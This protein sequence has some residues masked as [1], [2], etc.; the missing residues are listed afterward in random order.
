MAKQLMRTTDS[1]TCTTWRSRYTG[2]ERDSES[3]LD[4]FG[5]RYYGSSMGR[6]MSPD[7]GSDQHPSNPQSWNLYSYGRN[8]PLIGTDDDGHTYNV[9]SADGKSC[10]NI[11]DK[12][13]EANQKSDQANGV[14]YSNGTITDSSG[15]KQGSFSHDPDIAGDPSANIAA[16]GNIGNQGMGAIKY[17]VVGSVAGGALGAAGIAASGVMS[18]TIPSIIAPLLPVV[19]SAIDKLKKIGVSVQ[20]ANQI[21]NSPASQKLVDNLN[22]GNINFTQTVNGSLVRITTDPTG[23]RII[24]AGTMRANQITNGIA[25]GRFTP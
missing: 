22:G 24:S 8:N 2:K 20:Q 7:D 10:S 17:F 9:C 1:H 11:D 15:S 5:A 13:F 3:G 6:F 12:T 4:Y 18:A 19:P 21:V 16:M 14:N 23:Q 25:N